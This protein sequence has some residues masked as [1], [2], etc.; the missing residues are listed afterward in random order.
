MCS[1]QQGQGKRVC[2]CGML[3]VRYSGAWLGTGNWHPVCVTVWP[4]WVAKQRQAVID[5][6]ET[7]KYHV[8]FTQPQQEGRLRQ[9]AEYKVSL[10]G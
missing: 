8:M 4:V 6:C 1:A 9:V 2:Q 5:R 10:S 3:C 7:L